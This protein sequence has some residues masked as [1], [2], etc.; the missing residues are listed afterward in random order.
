MVTPPR[1]TGYLVLVIPSTYLS[2]FKIVVV[3]NKETH[4]ILYS[5][6]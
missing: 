2:R 1:V 6:K 5:C 4:D 3:L